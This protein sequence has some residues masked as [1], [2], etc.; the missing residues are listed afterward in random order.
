MAN[1]AYRVSC[2]D[3]GQAKV[4]RLSQ[5]LSSVMAALEAAIH[6]RRRQPFG[7]LAIKLNNFRLLHS[8]SESRAVLSLLRFVGGRDKPCH[9]GKDRRLKVPNG[10]A[11]ANAIGVFANSRRCARLLIR[12]YI[13]DHIMT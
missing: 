3:W 7:H 2:I 5:R 11:T 12:A 9:D 13:C 10:D 6:A 1:F 4:L 8:M